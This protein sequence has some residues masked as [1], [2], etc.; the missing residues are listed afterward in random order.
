MAV[1]E[2]LV[3][4]HKDAAVNALSKSELAEIFLGRQ[5]TL[6]GR[7]VIPLEPNTASVLDRFYLAATDMNEIRIKAY[8]AR[9]VF[10]GRGRPP[11]RVS[12]S[13]A[14]DRVSHEVEIIT[15]VAA[16]SAPKGTKILY[17]IP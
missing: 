2:I 9:E 15:F 3:L 14:I 13:D 11:L 4:V 5:T 6:G 10:S 8:W 1:E 16:S 7:R 17:R 12:Q